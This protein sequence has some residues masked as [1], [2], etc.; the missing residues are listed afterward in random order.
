MYV[1]PLQSTCVGMDCN[2]N[3][4]QHTWIEI[5]ACVS[6]Q[7][8][9]IIWITFLT[10]WKLLNSLGRPNNVY[11]SKFLAIVL[12]KHSYWLK[13]FATVLFG[14]LTFL[15]VLLFLINWECFWTYY[16]IM[17]IKCQIPIWHIAFIRYCSWDETKRSSSKLSLIIHHMLKKNYIVVMFELAASNL[18]GLNMTFNEQILPTNSHV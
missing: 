3:P 12:K 11:I 15:L 14:V 5:N 10:K 18:F 9:L 17:C 2:S 6:K 7:Y 4:L 16:V 1:Y 8:L 13:L